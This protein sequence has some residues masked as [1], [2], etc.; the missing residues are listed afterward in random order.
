ML[1]QNIFI[2][3][4]HFWLKNKADQAKLIEGLHILEPITHIK[5]IHI[6]VM[7]DTHRDV[8]D[9]TYD[10]SLLI[11]FDNQA[12]HDAYQIDPIHLVFVEEYAKPLCEKVVVQDSID[13]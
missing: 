4:V 7:A 3:H 10:A 5:Q 13:A 6:G 12:A 2:H 8:V 1:L 9:R 11:I